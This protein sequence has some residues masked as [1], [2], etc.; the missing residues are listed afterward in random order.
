MLLFAY[1]KHNLI[2]LDKNVLEVIKPY[3]YNVYVL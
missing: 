1:N 3:S 2:T